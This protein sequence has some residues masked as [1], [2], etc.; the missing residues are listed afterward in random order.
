MRG[1]LYACCKLQRPTARACNF[2]LNKEFIIL[3]LSV[4]QINLSVFISCFI[5]EVQQEGD[6]FT[7]KLTIS[8]HTLSFIDGRQEIT[9]FVTEGCSFSDAFIIYVTVTL[10]KN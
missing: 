6:V 7:I 5:N 2:T 9:S 8:I 1:K 4:S 3:I 10:V